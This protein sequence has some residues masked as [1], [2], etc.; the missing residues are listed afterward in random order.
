MCDK[1]RPKNVISDNSIAFLEQLGYNKDQLSL[2]GKPVTAFKLTLFG[3][4]RLEREGQPLEVGRR[5]ALAMLTYLAATGQSHNRDTLA[6]LFWPEV[7]QRRARGNLRR[8]LSD[9]NQELGEGWLLLEG[10]TVDLAQKNGLWL[11]V[12]Q[13]RTC[14]AAC[15]DHDHSSEETC[16]DCL[17]LLAEAADLY[18]ADFL[19]GFSLRDTPEFDDWQ[20]FEAESL[21]QEY[22]S[23]LDRLVNGLSAQ[24]DYE[25]AIPHARRRLALDRLHEPA[26]RQLMRLYALAG[27]RH[28]ALRQY[29]ACVEVLATELDASP[30]P[31]TEA[32][33]QQIIGGEVT[34]PPMSAPKPP[35][36]PPAPIAVEVER[37]APMVGREEELE[38]IQAQINS[39]WHGQGGTI[40]LAGDSGVGKTRLAYEAL[41][42]AAQ[43]G[44]IT[45][46]G[47]AYEQE[48]HLAYHPFIEAFDRYLTEQQRSAEQNPISH[49]KPMGVSDL[50]KENTALFKA[51]A[52]FLT[53]LTT[54]GPVVLLLDDLHGADEASLSMFHYLARQTRSAP[55]FLLATYRTDI[56]LNGVSPLG[57]LLNALYRERLSEVLHLKPLP[58]AAGAK[59]INHTL[60]GQTDPI[61]IKTIYDITEGNPFFVQE[62]T[63]AMLKADGLIQ[64][65]G[66]WR[67]P[68]GTTLE[69]PA[70]LQELLRER[71]QRLGPTVESALT[72]AAVVGREFRFAVLRHVTDL[73]DGD[74]FDALDAALAAHLLEET[75]TGYRFQHSLIRHTLYDAL[76]RRR[77][78][79]LHTRTGEAI[80][81]L[82][83]GRPEGLKPHIETLAF[84]YDLS[85]RRD[86]ALPYL[87]QAA[88][89]A[90]AIFAL[91]VANDYLE[92]ALALMD[93]L[94]IA[95]PAQ[96]WPILEQLGTLAKVLADT[97]RAVACYEQALALP[98]TAEWQPGPSDRVRLHRSTARSFIAAGRMAEAEQHLQTAMEIMADTGQASPDYAN[99]LYDVALWHW[100]NNEHQAAFEAAQRS[101]DI[102]EQLNDDTARAQAYEMLALAC[103]SLGEWQQGLSFEQQRST[104]A[105]PNLDVTEAFDAHL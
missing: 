32:L 6:T 43:A 95:D 30:A 23:V 101:L 89:N 91:E 61:L 17:P 70:G 40:L 14:L 49:Y 13:F 77:R 12:A 31:E 63:R 44:V 54:D 33:Y 100:H 104:L 26:Q 62:I 18:R 69:V 15:A 5:K 72:A 85:D 60:A 57:S 45:L 22:A 3:S 9:L 90:A 39:G 56:A 82:Y 67:L 42:S 58:E 80:E 98:P 37:S 71:V 92:R 34:P 93:D 24:A 41:R 50:Q 19:A 81:V 51:T 20:Y 1:T 99:L 46:V 74:L 65:E 102:A 96:R 73:S 78:A 94:G 86:Q 103:H 38:M 27:R 64:E 66:Q 8:A 48:G 25:A 83:S 76:S 53:S 87:K 105:G 21:R 7:P 68:P 29:Q 97:T 36:L 59:I 10:E 11:D 16:P 2:G 4:P 47:A 52:S 88:Q 75:D 28:E 84:H 35:W 55:I 79:W